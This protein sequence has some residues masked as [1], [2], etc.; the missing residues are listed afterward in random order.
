MEN[1]MRIGIIEFDYKNFSSALAVMYETVRGFHARCYCMQSAR[2]STRSEHATAPEL[3][4]VEELLT[5]VL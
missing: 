1:V 4:R 2:K 3:L 5:S